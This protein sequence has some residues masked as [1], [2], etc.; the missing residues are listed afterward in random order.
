[1]GP[2]SITLSPGF[3]AGPLSL[4]W[5]ALGVC[6]ATA[7]M[8]GLTL[9]E[10]RRKG[11]ARNDLVS[12]AALGIIAGIIGGKLIALLPRWAEFAADPLRE[13]NTSGLGIVGVLLGVTVT[14]VIYTRIRR[15]PLYRLLDAAAPGAALALA[16]G[17]IGCIAVGCCT[18]IPTSLPWGVIY[19]NSSGAALEPGPVH[20]THLY[21][22][23]MDLVLF[24]LIWSLRGRGG[25]REGVLGLGYVALYA[26]GDGLIS[27]LRP[28]EPWWGPLQSGQMLDLAIFLVFAFW[29]VLRQFKP[30]LLSSLKR[31]ALTTV[32]NSP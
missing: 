11:L 18:G 4:S 17:R 10:G 6:A 23:L 9:A 32:E 12:L 16:T 14:L 28:G 30:S 26:L 5:Y 3:T 24:G 25:R 13:F 8:I 20:P 7:V 1:M 15:I 31:G 22:L 21:L 27:F 29:V 2:I 19:Y